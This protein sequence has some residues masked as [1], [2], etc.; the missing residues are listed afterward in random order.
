MHANC[1]ALLRM[2][3]TSHIANVHVIKSVQHE[4]MYRITAHIYRHCVSITLL[5]VK[6][7]AMWR[8]VIWSGQV[9]PA[10]KAMVPV[11]AILTKTLIML[12][13]LL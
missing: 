5:T 3:D 1:L 7:M 11:K 6:T 4:R 2:S 9:V 8:T 13:I 10:M 12:N